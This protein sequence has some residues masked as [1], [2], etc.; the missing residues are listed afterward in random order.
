MLR[1]PLIFRAR[2]WPEGYPGDFRT[3]EA[4]Y[5]N[6]P[7]GEGV[8]LHLDRYFLSRSLAV[9]VRSRLRLLTRLLDQRAA[10]EGA[11]GRWLNL[12]CGPCRELLTLSSPSNGRLIHCVDSDANSLRYASTLLAGCA[13]GDLQFTSENAYRF[14]NSTRTPEK[15]GQLSTIYSAGLFDYIPCDKLA[16]LIRGL[17]DCLVPGGLLIAPFKNRHCYETFDYHWFVQWH[18]FYRR[19]EAD[20]RAVFAQAGISPEAIAVQRDDSGVLLFFTIRR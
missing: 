10:E 9:A 8:A 15:Y 19:S 6:C 20:F 11:G 14:V 5:A 17:Y 1:S 4:V 3:L 12:A 18:Y 16:P 7:A 13:P 2:R